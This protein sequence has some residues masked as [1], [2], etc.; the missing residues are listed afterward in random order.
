MAGNQIP[1]VPYVPLAH[2]HSHWLLI[3]FENTWLFRVFHFFHETNKISIIAYINRYWMGSHRISLYQITVCL[4]P[5]FF[6][7]E[8]YIILS[9]CEVYFLKHF[10]AFFLSFL[11]CKR[12]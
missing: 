2:Q 7:H 3:F 12:G 4:Q 6:L 10:A 9:S 8:L 11:N 5:A 1:Q